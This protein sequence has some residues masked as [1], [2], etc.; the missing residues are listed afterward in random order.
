MNTGFQ[1]MSPLL[2]SMGKFPMLEAEQEIRLTRQWQVDRDQ[3]ALRLLTGSHLRL[4][5][6]LAVRFK[7]YGMPFEDLVAAGNVGLVQ[8][9]DKFDP[10]RGVRFATYA[11]WWIRSAMQDYVV[12]NWSLVRATTTASRRQLF[13]NLRRMKREGGELG[14]GELPP[15]AVANIA[16]RLG[17]S[18]SDVVEMNR[19]MSS[20]DAS[21]NAPVGADFGGEW[22]DFLPD[23]SPDQESVLAEA[24]ELSKR[25]ALVDDAMRTLNAR[26]RHILAERRLRDEPS[27][28]D[29]LSQHYGISRERVRQIEVRAVEKLQAAVIRAAKTS[30]LAAPMAAAA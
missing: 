13:F 16:A 29:E 28:L 10:D 14:A 27:T 8:A 26:E 25:Q 5:A 22:G 24:E 3:R 4:V 19:H 1:Q 15:E 11:S 17:T 7:G 12:R 9:A 2:A 20:M 23:E 21:L 18:E 30:G 6:K